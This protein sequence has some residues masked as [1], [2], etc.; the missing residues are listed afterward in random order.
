[1]LNPRSHNVESESDAGSIATPSQ[2]FDKLQ[3][4]L[5]MGLRV[6][7]HLGRGQRSIIHDT[8]HKRS[9]EL[10]Q[11]LN[12]IALFV[13]PNYTDRCCD[14][15]VALSVERGEVTVHIA[16]SGG[17][18]PSETERE[19]V[20]M[21]ISILRQILS[22]DSDPALAASSFLAPLVQ[23]AFPEILRKL[24]LVRNTDTNGPIHTLRRFRDL[25]SFWIAHQPDGERSRGFVE[26]AAASGKHG[27]RA[28]DELVQ[29][30]VSL[31][32][33]D[34]DFSVEQEMGSNDMYALLEPVLN[35]CDLLVRSTFFDDLVNRSQYNQAL[36]ISDCQC[37]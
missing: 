35:S 31:M 28:T 32:L 21:L 33:M 37:I 9:E 30:F 14:I 23:K 17:G 7:E 26:M 11:L 10:V 36:Y 25:V 5:L 6:V 20:A 18:P 2:D 15:A 19:N 24:A 34:Q 4:D 3:L 13:A 8:C 22:G 1:M 27:Q 16:N 29:S 12:W